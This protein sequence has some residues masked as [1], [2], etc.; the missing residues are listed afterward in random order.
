M[1]RLWTAVLA[2]AALALGG[3]QSAPTED[4]P[5]WPDVG[6]AVLEREQTDT[7][8]PP[9]ELLDSWKTDW[10]D[11]ASTR[12]VGSHG[13]AR[14][15]V[16]FGA[17]PAAAADSTLDLCFFVET[18]D[19]NAGPFMC[20]PPESYDS[21]DGVET[22]YGRGHRALLVPGIHYEPGPGWARVAPNLY[23]DESV[24]SGEADR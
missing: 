1:K 8:V 19:Y 6:L 15:F 7:D 10:I 4:E 22:W 21:M 2:T 14:F 13:G 20:G 5:A 9:A 17:N 11:P 12:L 3:C 24:A 16:G 18:A 23:V